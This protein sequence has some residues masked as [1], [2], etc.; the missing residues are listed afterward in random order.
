[1]TMKNK[2]VSA[3]FIA[4][5]MQAGFCHADSSSLPINATV[6]SRNAWCSFSTESTTLNFG[7]INPSNSSPVTATTS[8]IFNCFRLL[9]PT[10]F[11]IN[12]DGGLYETG[13]NNPRMRNTTLSSQYLPYTLSLNPR[14]GTLTFFEGLLG[15][16]LEITGTVL[17][18]NYKTVFS[19]NYRDTVSITISP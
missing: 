4:V 1:M 14:T 10:V 17:P 8:V 15:Q 13:P 19:G 12:D 9:Q 3:V 6:V 2:I 16:T 11:A 5:L 18:A 7:T